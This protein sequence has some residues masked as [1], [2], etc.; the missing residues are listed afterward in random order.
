MRN[1]PSIW[2]GN[3]AS[4]LLATGEAMNRMGWV[5]SADLSNRVG[6]ESLIN[7]EGAMNDNGKEKL[8]AAAAAGVGAGVGGAGGASVGGVGL[9]ALGTAAGLSAGAV[10][11][12]GVAAGAI[13]GLAGYGVYRLFKKSTA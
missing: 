6:T 1:L 13:L 8:K 7:I 10:I 12:V 9:A 11:G 2:A 5:D 3:L 4:F